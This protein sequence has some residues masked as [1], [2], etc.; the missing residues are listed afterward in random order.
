MDY[1]C[2]CSRER[3]AAALHSVGKIELRRMLDEQLAEG[4]PEELEISCQFCNN[5]YRFTPENLEKLF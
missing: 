4:K 2:S 3:M 5:S 1:K